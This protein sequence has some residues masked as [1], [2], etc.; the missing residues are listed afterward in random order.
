MIKL[1]LDSGE[2]LI[3]CI[4]YDFDGV[5]TDN[6][7]LVDE[8]G[9]ES[10]FVN[11][12]DGYAIARIKE[13]GIPQVII[14]TETNPVVERRAEKL[15]LEIIHGVEDKGKIL[16]DYCQ[17]NRIELGNVLFIGNDL[18]DLSAIK[19]AGVTGAPVDAE[20]EIINSVDL[21]IQKKGG[22]GVIRELYRSIINSDWSFAQT[23]AYLIEKYE[24]I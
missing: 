12:G 11:R 14:S 8:N 2:K 20:M 15:G 4:A 3:S 9:K 1:H 7:V 16:K 6:R 17:K 18:N 23:A 21:I 10:V 5:M 24:N 22:H 13:M 19:V